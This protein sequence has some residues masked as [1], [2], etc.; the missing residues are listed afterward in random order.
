MKWLFQHLMYN[1][2]DGVC[3]DSIGHISKK[4]FLTLLCRLNLIHVICW[5]RGLRNEDVIQ[6]QVDKNINSKDE[7]MDTENQESDLE[8][9]L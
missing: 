6:Q 3:F 4:I 9:K 5:E 7:T 8:G 1:M 2:C